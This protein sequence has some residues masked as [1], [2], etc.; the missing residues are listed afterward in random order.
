MNKK[1]VTLGLVSVLIGIIVT[2]YAGS[3][4]YEDKTAE[5]AAALQK[6]NVLKHFN[7]TAN[8]SEI[9][10]M[11]I[12]ES[13]AQYNLN[14]AVKVYSMFDV[15]DKTSVYDGHSDSYSDIVPIE[16]DNEVIGFATLETGMTTKAAVAALNKMDATDEE[17]AEMLQDVAENEGKLYVS[18]SVKL[19]D[20]FE[21]VTIFFNHNQLTSIAEAA[22]II[23]ITEE[24]YVHI[25][26]D[27]L[28][29]YVFKA[30]GQE[31]IIPYDLSVSKALENGKVYPIG[32]AISILTE[33][34]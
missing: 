3:V 28:Y 11:T 31:Y 34:Y 6:N 15:T 4:S 7:E 25:V 5:M 24:K 16:K 13:E 12:S 29:A 23:N 22:G 33:N 10:V 32:Q 1:I 9:S 26:R 8:N 21:S 27:N 19:N 2:A 14:K 17:K 18:S 30:D 20:D